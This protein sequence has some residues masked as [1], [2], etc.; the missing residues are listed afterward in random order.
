MDGTLDLHEQLESEL[1]KFVEKEATLCYTTEYQTNLGAISAVLGKGD[2]I[3]SD[4]YNHAS[5]MDA[6]FFT[7]GMKHNVTLKG[8]KVLRF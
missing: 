5:I 3:M 7:L 8:L 6:V 4:K 2:H 1:A